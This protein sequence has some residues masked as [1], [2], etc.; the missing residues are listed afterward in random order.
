MKVLFATTNPAKI[1]Y[2]KEELEKRKIDV[3]TIMDLDLNLLIEENGKNAVE[4]ACI[5]AEAYYNQTGI[6]TIAVD[7]NLFIDGLSDEEQ[8]KDHVRRVNG[9]RL[10]DVE[11]IEYYTGIA[12]KLGGHANGYWLHGI[13]VC[14]NGNTNTYMKKSNRIFTDRVSQII[15]EGYPLD[16]ISIVPEY[17]KYR[18]ELTQSEINEQQQVNNKELFDF[19][20]NNI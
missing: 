9:K 19:I 14:K 13:A 15:N 6:T 16:S 20:I 7:D 12:K 4:N 1:K 17:N 5:K 18:S 10:D 11:M 8:P 3:L 2:Y